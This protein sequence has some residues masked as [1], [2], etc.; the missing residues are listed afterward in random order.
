MSGAGQGCRGVEHRNGAEPSGKDGVTIPS[1]QL[2]G[3]KS[4]LSL[5][6]Q[7]M[8][9]LQLQGIKECDLRL[10][11][12]STPFRAEC[13][14]SVQSHLGSKWM[15][16]RGTQAAVAI[17]GTDKLGV[18]QNAI[19]IFDEQLIFLSHP[20][21]HLRRPFSAYDSGQI[22]SDTRG[23][24]LRPIFHSMVDTD[25]EEKCYTEAA[26]HRYP[27]R[28][29][30]EKFGD[31]LAKTDLTVKNLLA[32]VW[33][34]AAF[35]DLVFTQAALGST[36]CIA[37]LR[38]EI[39]M[40]YVLAATCTRPRVPTPLTTPS[41]PAMSAICIYDSIFG[42]PPS[43]LFAFSARQVRFSS[44]SGPCS[45]NAEPEPGPVQENGEP[46]T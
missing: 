30:V 14:P 31:P 6:L 45:P 41:E 19:F 37:I 5:Q 21:Q 27:I 12:C 42:S 38:W 10:L 16:E 39:C 17:D 26:S 36:E 1:L 22:P 23:G 33:S 24:R 2:P 44:G 4:V 40:M 3:N 46:R 11:R 29:L 15:C 7:G 25:M 28:N 13:I 32:Q 9:P 43:T 8:E 34:V 20:E 35:L 18:V